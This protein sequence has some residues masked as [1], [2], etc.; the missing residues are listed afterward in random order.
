MSDE[1][2]AVNACIVVLFHRS[3]FSKTKYFLPLLCGLLAR[4]TRFKILPQSVV[5]M[6]DSGDFLLIWYQ[7]ITQPSVL[8]SVPT[9]IFKTDL[10]YVKIGFSTPPVL[11]P[12]KYSHN[13]LSIKVICVKFLTGPE[14]DHD[15][16][17]FLLFK[18]T[19]CCPSQNGSSSST[20]DVLPP[21]N[22]DDSLTHHTPRLGTVIPNRI[23]VG[24][25]DYK[26]RAANLQTECMFGLVCLTVEG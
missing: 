12:C 25:I 4:Q 9:P 20:P 8:I 11:N 6:D 15:P 18:F 3:F 2:G 21:E 13:L 10:V 23:F 19:S 7:V 17:H 22:H 24:G 1:E 16:C 5:R 14:L 26:V